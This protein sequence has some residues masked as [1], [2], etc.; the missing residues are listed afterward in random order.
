MIR[1]E[2]ARP[3]DE[4]I[5]AELDLR[6]EG[7]E[8]SELKIVAADF[9]HALILFFKG[10]ALKIVLTNKEGEK[11]LRLGE[12]SSTS[13]RRPAKRVWSGSWLRFRVRSLTVTSLMPSP[14]AR[15]RS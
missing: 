11:D 1:A 9:H 4:A 10:K 14:L 6:L 5:V 2:D 8:S 15:G 3:G 12:H 7:W 13:T